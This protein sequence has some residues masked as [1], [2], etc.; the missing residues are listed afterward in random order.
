MK[1]LRL[2]VQPV[3]Q[4]MQLPIQGIRLFLAQEEGFVQEEIIGF[5]RLLLTADGGV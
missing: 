1:F 5:A 4:L 2:A 3:V